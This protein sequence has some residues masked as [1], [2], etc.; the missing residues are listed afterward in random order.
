MKRLLGLV[1]ALVPLGAG[2]ASSPQEER[3]E[4][5]V[6]SDLDNPPFAM[7]NT[8]LRPRGR[9]V[10]MMQELA[11]ALDMRVRWERMPFDELLPA[12][13]AGDVDVVCATLGVTPDRAERMLF[14]E[15]YFRTS[16]AVVVR[17]SP[18]APRSFAELAGRRVSAGAGTTSERA[19][20][21]RLPSAVPVLENEKGLSTAERLLARELDAAVMDAPAADTM[22]RDSNWALWT[23]DGSLGEE[24]YALALPRSHGDLR[25]RLNAAL[26]AMVD[27]GRMAELN[28]KY[29]LDE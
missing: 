13:E 9:D 6:A 15:P 3:D 29:G 25:E 21:E 1:L 12:I 2:C 16:I 11:A 19:L 28:A 10:E 5:V 18:G 22:V 14:T 26:A 4:L 23:I 7:V 24:L 8:K 17:A 27:S 20:L